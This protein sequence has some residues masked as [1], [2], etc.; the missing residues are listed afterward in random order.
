M[1]TAFWTRGRRLFRHNDLSALITIPGGDTM[2]PPDLPRDAPIPDILHPLEIGLLPDLRDDSSTAISNSLDGRFSQRF[3]FYK[4]LERKVRLYDRPTTITMTHHVAVVL[5]FDQDPVPLKIFDHLFSTFK[6]ISPLIGT[7][8]F[9]HSSC[10]INHL[11]LLKP[12]L[13]PNFKIIKI[14]SRGDL[15]TARPEF[16]IHI[17][18]SNN[19]NLSVDHGKNDLLSNDR[20]IPFILGVD[21]HRRIPKHGFRP[22]GCHDDEPIVIFEGIFEMIKFPQNLLMFH[23]ESG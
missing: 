15:Q 23:F 10:F 8:I 14:M 4:P 20:V 9:I 19:R 1:K 13:Q 12:M 3:G 5:H 16:D 17:G 7:C 2:P 11:N 6:T 21:R 22:G 18:V